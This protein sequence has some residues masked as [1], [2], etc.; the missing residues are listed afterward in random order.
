MG[1]VPDSLP[2]TSRGHPVLRALMLVGWTLVLW[3]TLVAGTVAWRS[4]EMGPA[5][6][7]RLVLQGAGREWGWISLG[8]AALAVVVW[9]AVGALVVRRHLPGGPGRAP[10]S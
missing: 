8:C 3:G 1:H 9:T 4:A 10:Q 5:A 2:E 6:A 7:V